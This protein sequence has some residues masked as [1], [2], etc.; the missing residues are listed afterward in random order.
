VVLNQR[1]TEAEARQILGDEF[2]DARFEQL[3]NALVEAVSGVPVLKTARSADLG[4]DGRAVQ[5]DAFAVP[6]IVASSIRQDAKEK[7]FE[8]I[9]RIAG[10]QQAAPVFICTS[11]V[12]SETAKDAIRRFGRQTLGDGF[13]LTVLSQV[14]MAELVA[15]FPEEFLRLYGADLAQLYSRLKEV[16]DAPTGEIQ[17]QIAHA[18]TSDDG[19]SAREALADLMVVEVI[20]KQRS[21]Q[22]EIC[23]A[24]QVWLRTSAAFPVEVVRG[25]LQRITASG[26]I[27]KGSDERFELTQSGKAKRTEREHSV[28]TEEEQRYRDFSQSVTAK[29]GHAVDEKLMRELWSALLQELAVLVQKIGARF[30]KLVQA[31]RDGGDVADLR[32]VAG[33]HIRAA[34]ERAVR[35][36]RFAK[37]KEEIVDAL[38]LALTESRGAAMPWLEKAL[39]GWLAACQLGLVREVGERIAPA[40]KSIVLALDTDIVISLLCESERD[41]GSLRTLLEGVMDSSPCKLAA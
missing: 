19:F 8:D 14:E 12:L 13:V 26:D 4:V 22:N 40:L 20:A 1:V 30:A 31:V 23:A 34:C 29:L 21:S 11:R 9:V 25:S 2:D 10:T 18:I 35:P 17:L 32:T 7:A 37:N 6:P 36:A 16:L 39:A 5:L 15:R 3:A 33:E 28:A 41:H 38:F 27:T 24:L